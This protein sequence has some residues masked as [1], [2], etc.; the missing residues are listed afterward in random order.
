MNDARYRDAERRLWALAGTAPREHRV[1]LARLGVTVRV[2]EVGDGRSGRVPPWDLQR[3][4]RLGP[5][6]GPAGGV[7]VRAAGPAGV[8]AVG[9]AAR[10]TSGRREAESPTTVARTLLVDLLDGLGVD[11]AHVAATSLS[12]GWRGC[13]VPPASRTWRP[14]RRGPD[15]RGDD[16]RR[17]RPARGRAPRCRL[18]LPRG[19]PAGPGSGPCGATMS[20]LHAAA[21]RR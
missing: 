7:P 3:R 5:A 13:W 17:H 18:S 12:A 1:R 2:E 4:E 14:R 19:S 11:S 9:A 16:A 8:R 6:G 20:S 10:S 21:P 15:G